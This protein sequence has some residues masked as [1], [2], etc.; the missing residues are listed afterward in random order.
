[1]LPVFLET[2]PF[3]AVIA[4]G[5]LSGRSGFFSPEATAYLTKFV[6]YF[7]LSAMLLRFSV[8]LKL[9]EVFS[10]DFVIAYLVG[11]VFVYV[12]ATVVAMLRNRGI[13]EAAV[14][15]QC[16]VIGNVG[17]LGIP[18]LAMLMGEDAVGYIMLVLAVDLIIFGSL[19]VILITGARDGR[20]SPAILGTVGLGLLKNP[21]I[22]SIAIG[23]SVSGFG[24]PVPAPVNS[25]LVLLGSAATPGAL[26][27]IGASLATKSAER[28]AVAGWLS[29]AKLVLHPAA[30]TV[31][32]LF[33]FDVPPYGAAVMIA[34]ASLPV[35]GNVYI[36]AQ[37][38]GVAPQR[39]S[40]SI[41]ISTAVS[42]VTVSAVI[43]W[44]MQMT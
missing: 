41:L 8:N 18:M 30:V 31:C 1:M 36:L 24:L 6:F 28:L 35:A 34:A 39:V 16:A 25:F 5:Y 11:S 12:V 33:L 27:A 26:F 22:V 17:F 13:E 3:F 21:M 7:A 14:E 32:A 19:I 4:L 44:V 29:F 38:Y 40:A 43:A 10:W 15:S 20:M 42:V 23:L 9:G 2:L 37:H